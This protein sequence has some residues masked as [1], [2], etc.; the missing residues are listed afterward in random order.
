MIDGLLASGM[1]SWADAAD[2]IGTR[3]KEECEAHYN[4]V[5]VSSPDWPIP[6]GLPGVINCN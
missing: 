6:V 4:E 1:G 5:Y 2:Y 3:T